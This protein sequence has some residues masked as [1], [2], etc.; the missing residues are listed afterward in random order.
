MEYSRFRDVLELLVKGDLK[1]LEAILPRLRSEV[2]SDRER[3]Y[4]KAI[5]GIILSLK[6]DSPNLYVKMV[7]AMDR[8]S[9][10]QEMEKIRRIFLERPRLLSDEF[11]EGF[12]TCIVDFMKVLSSS[13]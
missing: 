11:Q 3:G 8:A 6:K 7:Y 5:E 2:S 10:E 4:L 1:T 12:F 9:I 13:R